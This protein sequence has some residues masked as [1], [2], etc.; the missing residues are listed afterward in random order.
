LPPT[1]LPNDIFKKKF[2][3]HSIEHC[4][5]WKLALVVD[6]NFIDFICL[7]DNKTETSKDGQSTQSWVHKQQN[8]IK[9]DGISFHRHPLE[10][11]FGACVSD[12][13]HEDFDNINNLCTQDNGNVVVLDSS[14]W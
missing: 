8:A 14:E 10:R 7:K 11:A 6:T 2:F 5:G 9:V 3:S 1:R 12:P 13:F 4:S